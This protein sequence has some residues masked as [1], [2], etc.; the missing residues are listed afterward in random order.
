MLI[1]LCGKANSGKDTAADFLVKRGDFVK[2]S[3]ADPIKRAAAE[4]FGWGEARL[5]GPSQ[6]RNE[7]DPAFN[8]LSARKALQ[9]MGTEVGRELYPDTW[10]EIAVRT[11]AR[12]QEGGHT[13]HC[14]R[15]LSSCSFVGEDAA[16]AHDRLKRH[17]VIADVRFLNE[18]LAINAA[19]GRVYQLTRG[20][21]L[22]GTAG[23]HQS[24]QEMKSI[25]TRLF[26]DIID[27][28]AWT[29]EQLEL[30]MRTVPLEK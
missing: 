25:P 17:V 18:V 3:L 13:Y 20:M 27:N 24:E 22:E 10:V 23:M 9:F 1:G 2:I 16:G 7:P 6:N 21:G 8:G 5:W 19:G 12:L 26:A 15:G 4:W 28:R 14:S 29:L 30:F 11:A